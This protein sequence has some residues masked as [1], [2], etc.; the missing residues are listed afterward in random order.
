[1]QKTN[2][3]IV[4]VLMTLGLGLQAQ[5]G[6]NEA[7]PQ[8]VYK[9]PNGKVY[10]ANWGRPPLRQTR[11]FRV[12]PGGYGRGSGTLARWIQENLDNDAKNNKPAVKP[13]NPQPPV[14]PIAIGLP[15]PSPRPVKPGGAKKAYPKHWGA[16]PRLQTK[17][18]R[19]LPGGYGFGSSTMAKWIQKNLDNDAKNGLPAPPVAID[20]VAPRPVAPPVFDPNAK[21]RELAEKQAKVDAAKV[22]AGIKVWEVAKAKCKG[23]YSYK[24]GFQSWVGFGHETTIVVKNNKVTERH[25]R[26]FNRRR[27]VAPPRPG[28]VAPAQPKTISWVETGKAI[29]TNKKGAPARTL[30]ELY[31]IALD[32][33]KKPLQQFERRYIRSDKQGLL[34]SCYIMD[35]RIADDAPR[36]GLVVSSI[37][38]GGGG[39]VAITPPTAVGGGDC[40]LCRTEAHQLHLG[41]TENGGT[42]TVK[43]GSTLKVKLK[44][45]PTTGFTWND[46]TPADVLKLSGKISHQAGGRLLGAPGMSTATYQA[47]KT[48]K[49]KIVLEYKRVFE[50][51]PPLNTVK[52]NIVV[53]DDGGATTKPVA[54]KV[55]RS[56]NGKAFPAH[57]GAPPRLQTRDLRPLPGGYGSGS[58]T[59][60]RWIQENLNKDAADPSR[61]NGTTKPKPASGNN[62]VRIAALEKEIARMKD[63]ARR[64]RFTREGYQKHKTKLTALEN[65]LAQLKGGKQVGVPTFEEWVKG[66]K[67]IPTGKVFVGGSPWFNERTGKRRNA[68]E[69]YKMLFGKQGGGNKPVHP[70]PIRPGDRKPF[71]AHWGA[72]P[73]IQTRDLRPL[74]GGYGRGSGTLAKWIQQNLDKDAAGRKP[75]GNEANKIAEIKAQIKN[76]ENLKK[77]ARFTPEGLAKVNAQINE[78]RKK[79]AELEKEAEQVP[80]ASTT[81]RPAVSAAFAARHPK[82]S[83]VEGRLLVG[84]EK[85]LTKE[86]SEKALISTIPGLKITKSMFRNTILVVALPDTHN[87]EQAMAALKGVK[88]VKY[89]ELDGVV[90]IPPVQPGGLGIG[91]G[92][93]RPQIQPRTPPRKLGKPQIQPRR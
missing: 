73:R 86:Q 35:R 69:V 7:K 38:L 89:S 63:F 76:L 54:T 91:I 51:K 57:W 5:E 52:I 3:I 40:A 60:A 48:G 70:K 36:N 23:N 67:K 1:M 55:H 77:V 82:G 6:V 41:M 88:G 53:T 37:Q 10:P 4:L 21:V 8:S 56:A 15:A 64:A 49:S 65:E 80:P 19:P 62:R 87:E 20:P 58:G 72:P 68:E 12:L 61:G 44:G 78:L 17:D 83:Y 29:G 22:Q 18:L 9:A 14:P 42:I 31:V 2:S 30:D 75:G 46:K 50:D 92:R 33:A 16:P 71:P 66:G 13:V 79:L 28:G 90:G 84:M 26:T 34:V 32:T 93:P 24:I 47:M 27:P 59:L 25:Y 39:A 11:D 43:K 45:N 74:P 81:Q 85:G